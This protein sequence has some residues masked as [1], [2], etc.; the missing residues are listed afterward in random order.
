M[1]IAVCIST[2][3]R[4]EGLKRLINGVDRLVFNKCEVP[5]VE[6]IVVDND[7]AGSACVS[8]EGIR[9]GLKWPLRCFVEPRRGVSYTRNKAVASA[10]EDIDF[11]A[12][13]DDDE[14]PEP[15]WLDELLYV[16]QLYNADVVAGPV[17]PYFEESVPLWVK[18]GNFFE[19]PR[20]PTGYTLEITRTG[21]VLVRFELF[22]KMEKVFDERFAV[23]GGEDTHFFMRV[24]RAGYRIVWAEDSVVYEWIPKSRANVKWLLQRAYRGGNIYS[25]C[26]LEL[27]GFS[28]ATQAK[29]TAKAS[30]RIVQG[31]LLIPLALIIGR[32]MLVKALQRMSVG[33]GELVG[34]VG[35]RSG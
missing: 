20:H 18:R 32:H 17:L 24:Y 28:F 19:R 25:L 9:S 1:R 21:N 13:I 8:C 7:P 11:I 34:V 14:V 3:H 27:S 2:Y 30:G 5:E 23:S 35:K 29:R 10:K 15:S 16:Q 33:A 22:R 12:F 6:I 26:E 4:P 31:L